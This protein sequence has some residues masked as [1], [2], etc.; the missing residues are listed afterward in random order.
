MRQKA[1]ALVV[2]SPGF[3]ATQLNK[4]QMQLD[5]NRVHLREI[6]GRQLSHIEG[7]YAIA[8]ANEIFG[9]AAWDRETVFLERV[10]ET[11][12]G[13]TTT[14]GYIARIRIRV[15]AGTVDVAREGT[16]CGFATARSPAAAHERAV[17]SAETD[18]T[19][20]ALAT[21][22][23]Q[24]GLELY[25]KERALSNKTPLSVLFGSDGRPIIDNLSPEAFLKGLR[26]LIEKCE[27]AA[28]ISALL[29]WNNGCL[30]GL[31]RSAPDLRNA[32]GKHY[33]DLL[34]HLAERII[35]RLEQVNQ[36]AEQTPNGISNDPDLPSSDPVLALPENTPIKH[37]H[38]H[39]FHIQGMASSGPVSIGMG[40]VD[41]GAVCTDVESVGPGRQPSS[42]NE[43]TSK[44]QEPKIEA[45]TEPM[46]RI[47]PGERIDKST[48]SIGLERRR[49]SKLHLK[50]V[51]ELPCLI[52][53]RQPSH[54]HHIKYAQRRGMS[55]KVSDEFVV[56][57][58]SLHHGDL[59]RA[60]SEKAWWEKQ[61]QEPLAIAAGLWERFRRDLN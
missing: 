2:A 53:N 46:S 44:H 20:R 16:G 55:Q 24:F 50:R 6:E 18:A 23:A 57:L 22:G 58:C 56:P 59:H 13:E 26:Q 28:E 10:Q 36:L 5:P 14:C 35:R 17:K 54:A 7:W 43:P 12:K 49:R 45:I 37:G 4:L 42:Q 51:A 47:G 31:K 8:Q 41:S 9:Y 39:H 60:A 15:R 48:L 27:K 52:C 25:E 21:F 33:T 38:S 3:D 1:K 32:Q 11:T 19:K 30:T 29:L 61:G 34:L 40:F